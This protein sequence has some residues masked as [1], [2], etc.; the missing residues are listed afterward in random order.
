[1]DVLPE[2]DKL[3]VNFCSIDNRARGVTRTVNGRHR[4]A[5]DGK[6]RFLALQSDIDGERFEPCSIPVS[7]GHTVV[8]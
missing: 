3:T 2:K 1:M 5:T 7:A 6:C 8:A 4:S